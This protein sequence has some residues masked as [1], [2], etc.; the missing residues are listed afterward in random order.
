MCAAATEIVSEFA[1]LDETANIEADVSAIRIA[2]AVLPLT[3]AI[4][5]EAGRTRPI[6]ALADEDATTLAAATLTL[7]A[8]TL[9]TE[10]SLA[11]A[12]ICWIRIPAE[13]ALEDAA[14][15]AA[16]SS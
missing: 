12:E 14:M 2:A 5:A 9:T 1:E 10:L 8:E 15:V 11:V 6:E 3:A 4:V 13:L 16:A 7:C